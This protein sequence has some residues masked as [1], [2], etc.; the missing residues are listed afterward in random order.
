MGAEF[1]D[2]WRTVRVSGEALAHL[3][4]NSRKAAQ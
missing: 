4:G 2:E 3:A 1:M